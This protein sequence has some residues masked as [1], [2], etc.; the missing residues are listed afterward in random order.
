MYSKQILNAAVKISAAGFSVIP[1]RGQEPLVKYKNQPRASESQIKKWFGGGFPQIHLLSIAIICGTVS[2]N[3]VVFDFDFDAEN[4]L[5]TFL[6]A[7]G[8]ELEKTLTIIETGKGF[9]VYVRVA[10]ANKEQLKS[11]ILA[12]TAD[13]SI[14]IEMKGEGTAVTAPPSRHKNGR[15]YRAFQGSLLTLEPVSLDTFELMLNQTKSQNQYTPKNKKKLDTPL[16]TINSITYRFEQKDQ[17]ERAIKYALQALTNI[18]NDLALTT[19]GNRNHQLNQSAFWLGKWVG[20]G[21]IDMHEVRNVLQ[22]ASTENG[23]IHDDGLDSFEATFNSGIIAGINDPLTWEEIN[24]RINQNTHAALNTIYPP[25]TAE[26]KQQVTDYITE[27]QEQ[28][29]WQLYHTQLTAEARN[30]WGK[31][32]IPEVM[33]NAYKFGVCDDE[34]TLPINTADGI[35]NVDHI[36][37]GRIVKSET[38]LHA[39]HVVPPLFEESEQCENAPAIVVMNSL[40]AVQMYCDYGDTVVNDS[41]QIYEWVGM[42]QGSINRDSLEQLRGRDITVLTGE[43]GINRSLQPLKQLGA[44]SLRIPFPLTQMHK[45]GIE[46]AH[47]GKLLQNGTRPLN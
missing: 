23:L 6:N 42:P 8:S 18:G 26:Q 14:L 44:K 15:Y 41:A 2:N 25:L 43:K 1:A 38:D 20:T 40:E 21:L 4:Q 31:L 28:L 46:S 36:K 12:R 24:R 17:Q 29:K 16:P 9:H 3:L 22:V 10:N 7:V 45:N 33:V 47:L 37:D 19:A 11:R 34:L 5:E 13:G 39:F 30:E 35:A 27:L 32:G